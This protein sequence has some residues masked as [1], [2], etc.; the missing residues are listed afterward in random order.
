VASCST[1]CTMTATI[2]TATVGVYI[3][4]ILGSYTTTDSS[5]LVVNTLVGSI[6]FEVHVQDATVS[7]SPLGSIYMFGTLLLFKA[8]EDML[9][10]S[11]CPLAL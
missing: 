10:L 5:T 11:P 7:T 6:R 3:L 1:G 2:N 4:Y 8:S 9:E